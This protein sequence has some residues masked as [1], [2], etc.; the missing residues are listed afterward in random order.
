MDVKLAGVV[1]FKEKSSKEDGI[2][3]SMFLFGNYLPQESS[4]VLHVKPYHMSHT[5]KVTGTD[6]FPLAPH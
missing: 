5:S 1:D 2:P 3:H 6:I 4:P